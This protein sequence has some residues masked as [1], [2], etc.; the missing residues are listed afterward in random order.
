MKGYQFLRRRKQR[1]SPHE[2]PLICVPYGF[3]TSD[4]YSGRLNCKNRNICDRDNKIMQKLQF[5]A[6]RVAFRSETFVPVVILPLFYFFACLWPPVR[7]VKCVDCEGIDCFGPECEGDYCMVAVYSPKIGAKIKLGEQ[8]I[9]KGCVT[10]NLLKES[11]NDE[12]ER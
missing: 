9:V 7:A 4:Y 5:M 12:C 11:L 3:I 1:K 6:H 10:G 8:N 2:L